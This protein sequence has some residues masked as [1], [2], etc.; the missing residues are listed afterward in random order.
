MTLPQVTLWHGSHASPTSSTTYNADGLVAGETDAAGDSTT[1]TYD[2]LDRTLTTTNPISG[3]TIMTY[4]PDG[5]VLNLLETTPSQTHVVTT[6]YNAADWPVTS[7][8]D[9]FTT[10]TGYDIA[11]RVK[12]QQKSNG[13]W[14]FTA[15]LDAQG[16]ETQ[17][18]ES[19]SGITTTYPINFTYNADNLPTS[20]Q[21][22]SGV[23]VGSY[24]NGAGS[25]RSSSPGRRA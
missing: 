11:G 16:R 19:T 20:E 24:Y 23:T 7:N 6:T 15:T 22:A 25:R 21:L 5:N 9:G 12:T 10:T 13:A 14:A 8:D 2:L 18:I 17:L 4:D 1:S 3:T